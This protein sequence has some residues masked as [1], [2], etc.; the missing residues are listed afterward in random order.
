MTSI[1]TAPN[2]AEFLP[3]NPA[4]SVTAPELPQLPQRLRIL[5]KVFNAKTGA[6]VA[7]NYGEIVTLAGD[8]IAGANGAT[9]RIAMRWLK[10]IEIGYQ[11]RFGNHVFAIASIDAT[12]PDKRQIVFLCSLAGAAK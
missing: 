11:I 5:V 12:D 8:D 2:Q 1:N 9:H 6:C 3:P 7:H 10:G 4:S